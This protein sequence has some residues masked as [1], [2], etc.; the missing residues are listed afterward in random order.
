MT[1]ILFDEKKVPLCLTLKL[2]H[3]ND[4]YKSFND[5]LYDLLVFLK[6]KESDSISE[7]SLSYAFKHP[8]EESWRNKFIEWC[9]KEGY[10]EVTTT[11]TKRTI[12]FLRSPYL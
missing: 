1:K 11:K 5:A 10:A 12:Q 3:K 9:G 7:H 6:E 2:H 4:E 8:T